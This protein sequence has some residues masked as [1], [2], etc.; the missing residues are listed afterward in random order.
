LV[1]LV[2]ITVF[3]EASSGARTALLGSSQG[4]DVSS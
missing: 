4:G 1:P 3:V 2:G